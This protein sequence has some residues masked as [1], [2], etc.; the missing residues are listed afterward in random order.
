[1]SRWARV[2]LDLHENDSDANLRHGRYSHNQ[3]TEGPSQGIYTVYNSGDWYSLLRSTIDSICRF[4]IR[5]VTGIPSMMSA[6]L[7][8]IG[9]LQA[10]K[11]ARCNDTRR[12][13]WE[14]MDGRRWKP[15]TRNG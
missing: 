7:S 1:M 6:N 8:R 4:C 11:S 15:R 2:Y 13:R 14:R 12:I 5:V 10:E 9:M 3:G